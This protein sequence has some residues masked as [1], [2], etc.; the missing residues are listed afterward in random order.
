M[1]NGVFDVNVGVYS[2]REFSELKWIMRDWW[3]Q[4]NAISEPDVR[5]SGGSVRRLTRSGVGRIGAGAF[6]CAN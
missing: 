2:V 6:G 1:N 3:T 4:K 5:L